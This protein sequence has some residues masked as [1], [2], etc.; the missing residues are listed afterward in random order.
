MMSRRVDKSGHSVFYE[1]TA[2]TC[3]LKSINLPHSSCL[4]SDANNF[5][6]E[7]H[8]SI[9]VLR[10]VCVAS[11]VLRLRRVI[12]ALYLCLFCRSLA[13]LASVLDH[14]CAVHL[15]EGLSKITIA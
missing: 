12:V 1:F 14:A 5:A 11:C 4:I 2:C 10:C 8:S 13:I 15:V 3:P 9:L 7:L 6:L